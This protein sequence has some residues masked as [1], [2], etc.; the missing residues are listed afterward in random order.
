MKLIHGLAD[1]GDFRR[2]FVSIGN[3]DGVHLG[4]A[5]I[6]RQLVVRARE[7]GA[8]AIVLT[9]DP[10]PIKLLR[11]DQAPPQLSTLEDRA[12]WLGELGADVLI[13][14]P[15]TLELLLLEPDEFF[16]QVVGEH[17]DPRGLVEGPNF[18]FGRE[19]GGDIE[20][21]ARLCE[22]VGMGL[23]VVEPHAA[24]GALV[25][26]SRIRTL[27][28]EGDVHEAGRML[29]RDYS[30]RGRVEIG[31][32]R[33]RQLDVPTANLGGIATLV[34]ADG[35]YVGAASVGGRRYPAA[36][37]IGGNPTF[38]EPGCKVEVHLLAFDGDLY[39]EELAVEISMRVRGTKKFESVDALRRQLAD[40]LE[41]VW[42]YVED[43]PAAGLSGPEPGVS[44]QGETGG[45]EGDRLS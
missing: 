39:G 1:T 38:G 24:G 31:Q 33:G 27:L 19:R 35:V 7:V 45:S 17:L 22:N 13:A 20:T 21:L 29:G 15:T 18:H 26:S 5:A 4:H 11:P 12:G 14:I 41:V 25:S 36:I 16:S 34:P 3:F 28:R 37:H 10:H 30:V 44:H 40:D 9:F 2:G 8:A 43:H 42:Q 6:V 32:G 23:D